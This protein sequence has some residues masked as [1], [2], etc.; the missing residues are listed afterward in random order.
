M[1]IAKIAHR[2][3]IAWQHHVQ[4]VKN[5]FPVQIEKNYPFFEKNNLTTLSVSVC[6]TIRYMSFQNILQKKI[7]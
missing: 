2:R 4:Q 7:S 3:T 1:T 6:K 5:T